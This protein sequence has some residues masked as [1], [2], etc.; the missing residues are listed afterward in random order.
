MVRQIS[1]LPNSNPLCTLEP[2]PPTASPEPIW[3]ETAKAKLPSPTMA[4]DRSRKVDLPGPPPTPAG[5][6][7]SPVTGILAHPPSQ[8]PHAS[9]AKRS[10][11]FGSPGPRWRV[12]SKEALKSDSRFTSASSA[13]VRLEASWTSPKSFASVWCLSQRPPKQKS[14][15]VSLCV[16]FLFRLISPRKYAKK[17][18]WCPSPKSFFCSIGIPN[19][20]GFPNPKRESRFYRLSIVS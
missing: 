11:R 1:A 7:R 12:S 10:R 16:F 15:G 8:V 6:H 4:S 9:G 20:S 3:A 2:L 18:E 17:I 19:S 13:S 14:A 5:T